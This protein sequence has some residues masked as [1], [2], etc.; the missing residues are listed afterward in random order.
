MA[1]ETDGWSALRV[2]AFSRT[3]LS[4]GDLVWPGCSCLLVLED[5]WHECGGRVWWEASGDEDVPSLLFLCEPGV[6]VVGVGLAVTPSRRLVLV[7]CRAMEKGG[8][9]RD[10][11]VQWW[12]WWVVGVQC[13]FSTH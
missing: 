4:S 5:V 6:R 8:F 12:V 2:L 7:G 11:L 13:R 1:G 10:D 9:E 3:A